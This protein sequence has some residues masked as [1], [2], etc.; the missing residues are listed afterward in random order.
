[1]GSFRKG[2]AINSMP[3][4]GSIIVQFKAKNLFSKFWLKINRSNANNGN[5]I[6]TGVSDSYS[7]TP[8]KCLK[9]LAW[10][11]STGFSNVFLQPWQGFLSYAA[12][13]TISETNFYNYY[14]INKPVADRDYLQP[15]IRNS[16]H[17]AVAGRTDKAT[18]Y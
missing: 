18:G 9:Y 1:L 5:L 15:G 13:T 6:Q 16:E 17:D 10:G 12:I 14:S 8:L 11:I 2:S 7:K 4:A 3:D